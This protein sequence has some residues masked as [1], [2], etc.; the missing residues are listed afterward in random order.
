MDEAEIELPRIRSAK[1]GDL[2]DAKKNQIVTAQ[3]NSRSETLPLPPIPPV[4]TLST[5][6]TSQACAAL[7]RY[8]DKVAHR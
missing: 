4:Y 2:P 6:Y 5:V 8:L 3:K 1:A 7:Q